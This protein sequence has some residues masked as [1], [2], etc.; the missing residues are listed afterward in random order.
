MLLIIMITNAH[1]EKKGVG[2]KNNMVHM[3]IQKMYHCVNNS[4]GHLLQN[5]KIFEKKNR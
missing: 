1:T 3:F 5:Y 2:K 4:N